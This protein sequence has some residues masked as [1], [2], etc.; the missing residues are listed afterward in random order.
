MLTN[1]ESTCVTLKQKQ[2]CLAAL[3]DEIL[4][5][6]SMDEITKE[7]EVAME[8]SATIEETLLKVEAFK[9][10]S[11][12]SNHTIA[13]D[14]SA[15]ESSPQSQHSIEMTTPPRMEICQVNSL[16][17]SQS[18]S[19]S[20]AIPN[21]GFK[22]PTI[23][24]PHF[25]GEITKCHSFWQNFTSA[26]HENEQITDCQKLTYVMNSLEGSAYKA[27][28]GLEITGKKYQ[29]AI[30]TLK[31]RFGKKQFVVNAHMQ[32]LLTVNNT[33]NESVPQLR[34][35]FDNLNM[36]IRGLEA[37]GITLERYGSLLIPIVM[38]RMHLE[39]TQQVARKMDGDE[40]KISD[41]LEVIQKEIDALEWS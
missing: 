24:L 33:P 37:L 1:L 17:N 29:N 28:D 3:D 12:K 35:I 19:G 25:Y 22:L 27:L 34:S 30:E 21:A 2:E 15:P 7:I 32:E 11:Y 4:E 41:I 20:S 8:T 14:S 36:H 31:D 5:K 39:I 26:V 16:T 6:C 18:H 38:S 9:N 40:W 13:V 10:G 23:A